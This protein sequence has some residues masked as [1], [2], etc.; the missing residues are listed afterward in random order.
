MKLHITT[1]SP[2]AR[3]ARIA[4]R[5]HGLEDR[6]EEILART[7]EVA[8]PY[9][10]VTPSGRVPFLER[11]DGPALEESDVIC[12]YF[13]AIG[14]GPPLMRSFEEQNWL[15]G[16]LHALARS[17]VD[18]VSVWGR[19]LK[20]PEADQ[21]QT[22]LAHERERTRRLAL[23][24]EEE[25]AAP[26]M[27]GP[28]NMAQITLCCALDAASYYADV[29]PAEGHQRLAAWHREIAQRASFQATAYQS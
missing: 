16:R 27:H 12:S 18:G 24:W 20:R 22:I 15:Y 9:Y 28:L 1:T 3:M 17:M 29:D 26:L 6:V 25:I 11:N 10:A 19:E 13:D 23:L 4:V 2:F 5:E 14:N 21:S 8:S 7:R